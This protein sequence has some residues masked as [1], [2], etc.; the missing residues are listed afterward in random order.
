MNDKQNKSSWGK[1]LFLLY[2]S[3]ALFILLLVFYVSFNEIN[4]VEPDYYRAQ[5]GYQKQIEMKANC[6]SL[7]TQPLIIYEADNDILNLTLP[8]EMYEQPLTGVLRF[9]RPSDYRLDFKIILAI[10]STGVQQIDLTSRHDGLWRFEIEW[11]TDSTRYLFES[12]VN[13]R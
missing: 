3:F 5:L 2:G 13:K 6:A 9:M 7:S 10:D 1:G 8:Q 12:S 11:Q 4:L